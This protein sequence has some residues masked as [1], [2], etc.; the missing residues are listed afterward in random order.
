MAEKN[1]KKEVK[2]KKKKDE[3]PAYVPTEPYVRPIMTQ[4]EL[5]AKKKKKGE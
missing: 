4:P 1:I 2:K 3:K 5:V